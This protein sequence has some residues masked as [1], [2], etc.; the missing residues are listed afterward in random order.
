MALMS[1][2]RS[3]WNCV[4]LRSRSLV[5]GELRFI[6]VSEHTEMVYCAESYLPTSFLTAFKGGASGLADQAV[7]TRRTSG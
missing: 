2:R 1:L 5:V 3:E 7:G 4:V 6:G